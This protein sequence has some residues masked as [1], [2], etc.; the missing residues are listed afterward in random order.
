MPADVCGL[1]DMKK[2]GAV[3]FDLWD[4]LIQELPGG[5]GKVA[6]AR[7]E[8]MIGVL[9]RSGREHSRAEVLEAYTKTGT[10]LGL[11]WGKTRDMSVRDQVLFML[12]CIE[13]RLPSKLA[14]DDF[15]EIERIYSDSMLGIRPVLMPMARETLEGLRDEG[16]RMGLISNTGRTPGSSLRPIMEG[17]GILEFFEVTT[18]SNEVMVRKPA[19]AIFRTTLE[20][21]KVPARSAVHIGDD[22][23][24]DV[25]GARRAGMAAIQVHS[26]RA[27]RSEAADA[28]VISLDEVADALRAVQGRHP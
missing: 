28:Y 6:R 4:T 5:S 3:T 12:S 1:A 8:G 15:S 22:P 10:F 23:D 26:A 24:S 27:D 19:E 9:K 14:P 17:L 25:M 20:G 21:L 16:H 11:A 7:I 18:F 13:C 2:P